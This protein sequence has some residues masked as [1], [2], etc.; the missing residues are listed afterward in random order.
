MIDPRLRILVLLIKVW[1]KQRN[2]NNPYRGTLSSYGFVLLVIHFLSQVKQPPVLP[3]LQQL[4]NPTPTNTQHPSTTH[5]TTTTHPNN[6]LATA[7]TTTTTTIHPN[8]STPLNHPQHPPAPHVLDLDPSPP[9]AT[10][11][12]T[13]GRQPSPERVET[14]PEGHNLTFFDD[15]D[16]LG[17][18]W[19]GTNQDSSG[20][21]AI[22]FFRYFATEYAY[23]D[24][25]ISIRSKQGQLDRQQKNWFQLE[26]DQLPYGRDLHFLSIED[27]F[28]L[29]Y[30]V[31]R[32]VT[33]EG[34]YTVSHHP[35]STTRHW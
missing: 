19:Q 21:L 14:S 5:T 35:R 3:N 12:A 24:K 18:H 1:A 29:D 28:Q 9:A 8:T 33:A 11:T 27:P 10:A 23:H 30:N 13:A 22:E 7:T 34:L 25:V 16:L 6:S 32:T 31:A 26:S 2:I 20:Q 17:Q 15:L 4:A